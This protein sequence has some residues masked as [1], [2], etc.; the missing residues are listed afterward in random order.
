MLL[1]KT[2][3][4]AEKF[5]CGSPYCGWLNMLKNSARNWSCIRSVKEMSLSTPISICHTPGPRNTLRGAFPYVPGAGTANA[6]GLIHWLIVEPPGGVSEIPGTRFGRWSL[7]LPCGTEEADRSTVTFTG[8]AVRTR[9]REVSCQE[10]AIRLQMPGWFKYR[11]PGPNR[12]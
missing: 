8:N 2:G 3:G 12:S 5:D 6:A 4:P 1:K 7:V 11:L 10:P 9:N